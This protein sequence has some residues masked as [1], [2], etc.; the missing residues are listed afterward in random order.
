MIL[1]NGVIT[2]PLIA[3]N[4]QVGAILFCSFTTYIIYFGK[5]M[6]YAVS[7]V[8]FGVV[9]YEKSIV[10]TNASLAVSNIKSGMSGIMTQSTKSMKN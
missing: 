3:Q 9:K 6:N 4:V 8:F 1:S 7:E 10:I 5:T 2:Q